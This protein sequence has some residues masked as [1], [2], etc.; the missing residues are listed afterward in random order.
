V[1]E[2]T[3]H[4]A[5]TGSGQSVTVVAAVGLFASACSYTINSKN[6]QRQVTVSWENANPGVTQIQVTDGRVVTKQ[7]A[8]TATGSWSTNVKTGV[9]SYGLWGGALR[10]DTGTTLVAAGTACTLVQ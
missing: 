9:P 8:P 6:G 10:R 4:L 7:L 2:G 1:T 5:A 3:N